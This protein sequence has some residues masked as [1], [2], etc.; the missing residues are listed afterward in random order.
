MRKLVAPTARRRNRT[1][2]HARPSRLDLQV[3]GC[4]ADTVSPFHSHLPTSTRLPYCRWCSALSHQLCPS[5]LQ[6]RLHRSPRPR[7]SCFSFSNSQILPSPGLSSA[8]TRSS[9]SSRPLGRS[10]RRDCPDMFPD[11][12]LARSA[13]EVALQRLFHASLVHLCLRYR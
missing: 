6:A 2:A 9:L 4:I 13:V 11:S 7:L 10:R 3:A 5:G 12:Y 8:I 1:L